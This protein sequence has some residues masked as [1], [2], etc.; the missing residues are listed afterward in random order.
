MKTLKKFLLC[1]LAFLVL[2]PAIG[3]GTAESEP[4]FHVSEEIILTTNQ[5]IDWSQYV[6]IKVGNDA[7][8]LSQAVIVLTAG[9][10][11]KSGKCTYEITY[12][13]HGQ[14]YEQSFEVTYQYPSVPDPEPVFKITKDIV[15]ASDQQ[16]DWSQYITITLGDKTIDLNQAEIKLVSGD[17]SKDGNCTYEVSYL[18]KKETFQVTFQYKKESEP[19]ISIAKNITLTSNQNIVW[20][21][22][23]AITV[24]G[25]LMDLS[26]AI[27]TLLSGDSY[28]NGTCTYEIAYEYQEKTYKKNFEVTFKYEAQSTLTAKQRLQWQKAIGMNYQNVTVLDGI[29]SQTFYCSES[30][31]RCDYTVSN[32]ELSTYLK[33]TNN[34]YEIYKDGAWTQATA[35]EIEQYGLSFN[36]KAID[37]SKLSYDES[38]ASF[39]YSS[40]DLSFCPLYRSLEGTFNH[41]IFCLDEVGYISYIGLHHEETYEQLVLTEFGKTN[42]GTPSVN[43]PVVDPT[44]DFTL[45]DIQNMTLNSTVEVS[46]I[47]VGKT[48]RG[49]LLKDVLAEEYVFVYKNSAVDAA[50]GDLVAVAGTVTEFGGAKQISNPTIEVTSHNEAFTFHPA[51]LA[52]S[53][54]TAYA[55]DIVVGLQASITGTLQISGNYYNFSVKDTS[56]LVSISYPTQSL[57]EYNNKEITIEGYL[58]YVSG[59]SKKYANLVLVN[60]I[61]EGTVTPPTT[62]TLTEE[63]KTIWTQAMSLD[64]NNY[65]LNDSVKS[66]TQSINK[67]LIHSTSFDEN[68]YVILNYYKKENSSLYIYTFTGWTLT[69]SN[70]LLTIEFQLLKNLSL[71]DITYQTETNRYII[72]TT[73]LALAS[74][75][76]GWKSYSASS[77][78]V[79]ITTEEQTSIISAVGIITRNDAQLIAISNV[80]TTTFADPEESCNLVSVLDVQD[81]ATDTLCT[82]TGTVIELTTTGFLVGDNLNRLHAAVY[83]NLGKQPEVQIGNQVKV[84]GTAVKQEISLEF[85]STARIELLE[86]NEDY[87]FTPDFLSMVEVSEYVEDPSVGVHVEFVATYKGN[88]HLQVEYVDQTIELI[89]PVLDLTSYMNK[90]VLVQGYFMY[91]D[92][93]EL[94]TN[95]I[96]MILKNMQECTEKNPY[97]M[98]LSEEQKN[99][100]TQAISYGY[101]SN[102]L[103]FD[104]I[105]NSS[106]DIDANGIITFTY[107]D[108]ETGAE[109]SYQLK[110][111][112]GTYQ[113]NEG[114]G[115]TNITE[116]EYLASALIFQFNHLD[117]TKVKYNTKTGLYEM[118]AVDCSINQLAPF[119]ADEDTTY[120]GYTF[121]IV[122]GH[123]GAV[124][125][126]N[127]YDGYLYADTC[128][129]HFKEA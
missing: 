47:V 83:V 76:P 65:T 26:S 63:Q 25:E 28:Q 121:L 8:D 10:D 30:M 4:T 64:Y 15:L 122:D 73:K 110:N 60:V 96:Y 120:I 124:Q 104:G 116:E 114:S 31:I 27:I 45:G 35:S 42:P 109:N 36:F 5:N 22:Y 90:Q 89:H 44:P 97:L 49:I 128:S 99:E 86:G 77:I 129:I 103:L 59:S 117:L 85:D 2:L 9:D 70:P 53:D 106:T 33:K 40:T 67:N 105:F 112:N 48:T 118:T 14:T 123:F 88:N 24:D 108:S 29:L 11:T 19:V 52:G 92:Y 126:I 51:S 58:I 102:V 39:V 127:L 1:A 125:I 37:V 93:T 79:E 34:G 87:A 101:T 78:F 119:M 55:N 50:I 38:L 82:I 113:V 32:N 74:L 66:S 57:S 7:I 61:E 43:P 98:D 46:G 80:G 100:F 13:I 94:G 91:T 115:W 16:I 23:I 68:G 69:T 3:C 71:E 12:E 21:N 41:S 54:I 6:E 72:S 95:S 107:S 81:L 111:E 17:S 62:E 20:D 75:I 18:S 56:V 84:F